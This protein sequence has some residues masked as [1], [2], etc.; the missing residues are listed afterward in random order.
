MS[1]DKS[2]SS[3]R[4]LLF[5]IG[6]VLCVIFL[7]SMLH[8]DYKNEYEALQEKYYNLHEYY[9]EIQSKYE[10][11]VAECDTL[12]SENSSLQDDSMKLNSIYET[13]GNLEND[14]C[15]VYFFF[16]EDEDENITFSEA[17]KA[18]ENIEKFFSSILD[19]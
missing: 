9:D 19:P 10:E 11:L 3:A 4:W 6:I 5:G 8:K 14:Y 13:I 1:S 18:Y 17:K 15:T 12:E 7:P 2:D 16:D